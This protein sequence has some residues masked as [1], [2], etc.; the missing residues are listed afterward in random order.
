MTAVAPFTMAIA[1]CGTARRSECAQSPSPSLLSLSLKTHRWPWHTHRHV[2]N[3]LFSF[4]PRTSN[5]ST[6]KGMSLF[7]SQIPL[8]QASRHIHQLGGTQS[9]KITQPPRMLPPHTHQHGTPP[10]GTS[11]V[12]THKTGCPSQ[13]QPPPGIEAGLVSNNQTTS[14]SSPSSAMHEVL[15][16]PCIIRDA[17]GLNER[18]KHYA[19][20]SPTKSPSTILNH[21]SPRAMHEKRHDKNAQELICKPLNSFHVNKQCGLMHGLHKNVGLRFPEKPSIHAA[22]D[23]SEKKGTPPI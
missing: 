19:P 16:A 14:P 15:P 18:T 20:L 7:L 22:R 1:S 5:S 4:F 3:H 6:A 9:V 13:R 23:H 10:L 11:S 12:W 2:M 17:R 8:R 21:S